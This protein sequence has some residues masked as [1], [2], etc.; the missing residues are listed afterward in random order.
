MALLPS[1]T[2]SPGGI[3]YYY[4]VTEAHSGSIDHGDS[5]T[6]QIFLGLGSNSGNAYQES[7]FM[8]NVGITVT[9][10]P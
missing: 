3:G 2:S 1:S 8:L 5:V 9:S 10:D 7:S 4:A 6:Y